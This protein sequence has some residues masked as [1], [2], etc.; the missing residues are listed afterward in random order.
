MDDY[1]IDTF[2]LNEHSPTQ[3]FVDSL[4][5]HMFYPLINNP[6]RITAHLAA[7]IDNIF[8]NNLTPQLFSGIIVNDLSDHLPVF[9]YT[10]KDSPSMHESRNNYAV[11]RDYSEHNI[12]TFRTHLTNVDWSNHSDNDPNIMY[13]NF[14]NE[15]LRIYNLSFSEKVARNN[16]NRSL[17]PWMTK[18][19]LVSVRKKNKLYKQFLTVRNFSRESRYKMYKNKLTHLIKAAKKAYYDK[20]F[21]AAKS[22]Q[23]ATW[24]LIKEV[25]NEQAPSSLSP[26]SIK[27]GSCTLTNPKDRANSF[28]KFFTN[29]GP[30]LENKILNPNASFRSHLD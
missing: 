8:T 27:T 1:N 24:K 26:S 14:L 9:A 2:H 19:L 28:C 6:T 25:I 20:R 30:E 10:F 29:I 11:I 17:M 3:D 12:A 22:N 23:K 18:V 5:S 7:L 13:N 15:L 4:Y 16:K 21:N